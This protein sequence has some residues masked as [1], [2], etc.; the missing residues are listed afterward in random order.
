MTVRI[1][2]FMKKLNEIYFTRGN[3]RSLIKVICIQMP[4]LSYLNLMSN[5]RFKSI[6]FSKNSH[7]E[8]KVKVF[9]SL[10]KFRNSFDITVDRSNSIGLITNSMEQLSTLHISAYILSLFPELILGWKSVA[11]INTSPLTIHDV[12]RDLG[13]IKKK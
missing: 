4:S 11:K 10:F 3:T 7:V 13:T 8:G 12:G 5:V 6:I 1:K 9:A 2:P